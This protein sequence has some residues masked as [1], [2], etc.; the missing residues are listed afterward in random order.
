MAKPIK[1]K[2]ASG[3][4][5]YAFACGYIQAAK[6]Q[7]GDVTT[8]VVLS[9]SGG[10]CYHVVAHAHGGIGRL[11]YTATESLLLA[12][13]VWLEQAQ[14][15]FNVPLLKVKCDKRYTFTREF[16]GEREQMWVA[17][18]CG[19]WVGKSDT[20]VGAMLLAYSHRNGY[21]AADVGDDRHA[22]DKGV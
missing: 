15:H 12:R 6:L 3:L 17:R 16:M 2:Q 20:K 9:H 21:A 4:T 22:I 19:E 8:Q 7:Q 1:F 5:A 10:N 13:K 11:H 18:F 14:K